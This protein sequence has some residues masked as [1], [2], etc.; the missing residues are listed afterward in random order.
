MQPL[1]GKPDYAAVILAGGLGSRM[2]GVDKGLVEWGDR[3]LAQA[4]LNRLKSQSMPPSS[5]WISANRNQAAYARALGDHER[6]IADGRPDF[7]GPLCGIESALHHIHQPLLLAVPCDTP[8][9]PTDLFESL[10]LAM[11]QDASLSAAYAIS[12][13]KQSHPLCC[14]LRRHLQANLTEY[15]DQGQ[16]RV[17]GWMQHIHAKAVTFQE[18]KAFTNVNDP[19]TLASLRSAP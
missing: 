9:L 16:Q 7:A 15:I 1:A 2:G 18:S 11:M 5:I 13:T 4:V 12:S 17:L 6:I 14:L 10:Y 19:Q 8:L 3:T